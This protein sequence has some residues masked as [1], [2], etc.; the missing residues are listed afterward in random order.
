MGG[1]LRIY[2]LPYL[3]ISTLLHNLDNM[4]TMEWD[5]FRG[6]AS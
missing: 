1:T 5:G 4:E 6:E 3:E 2:L